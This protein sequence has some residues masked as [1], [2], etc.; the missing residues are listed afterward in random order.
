[1][2][3][4]FVLNQSNGL[5]ISVSSLRL[6]FKT[7][8]DT[9]LIPTK[10]LPRVLFHGVILAVIICGFWLLDSLKDPILTKTVGIEYQPTAKFCSVITTMIVVCI[11]DYSRLK[12]NKINSFK[13]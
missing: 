6:M 9:F 5:D 2:W 7:L 10:Q 11:Y 12:L 4:N 13:L 3:N 1:M 8:S